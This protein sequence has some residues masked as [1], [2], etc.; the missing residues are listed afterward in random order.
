M[1]TI[2]LVESD[3][4]ALRSLRRLLEHAGHQVCAATSADEACRMAEEQACALAVV[5]LS[6]PGVAGITVCHCLRERGPTLVLALSTGAV[7]GEHAAALAAGARV[8]LV[9]PVTVDRLLE[10]IAALCSDEKRPT[11]PDVDDMGQLQIAP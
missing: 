1:A 9:K 2:L 3:Q 4:A 8:F 5:D 7:P 6:A 10:S 11:S